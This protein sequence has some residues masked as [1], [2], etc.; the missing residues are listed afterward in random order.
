MLLIDGAMMSTECLRLLIDFSVFMHYFGVPSELQILE[1][2]QQ[3]VE[4][5]CIESKSKLCRVI[6]SGI[7]ASDADKE[8]TNCEKYGQTID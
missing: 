2:K 6:R 7:D 3:P 1:Y 4:Y 8:L 5:H